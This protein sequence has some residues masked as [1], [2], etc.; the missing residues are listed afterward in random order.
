VII[1]DTKLN[2]TSQF[3]LTVTNQA[4]TLTGTPVTPFSMNFGET[5]NYDLPTSSDPEGLPYTT[6]LLSGPSYVTLL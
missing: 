4:P 5:Y 1:T 2:S 6:S 3:I